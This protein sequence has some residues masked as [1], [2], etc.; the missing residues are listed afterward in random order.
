MPPGRVFNLVD[1]QLPAWRKA[2]APVPDFA[3][4]AART[5]WRGFALRT[6]HNIYGG[7]GWQWDKTANAW[8]CLAILEHYAFIPATNN[9]VFKAT[10]YPIMKKTCEFWEDHLKSC[11]RR[12][13]G[14]AGRLVSGTRPA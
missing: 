7:M 4:P 6:S 14:R 10:A 3:I 9:F 8:Y 2:T 12:E 1:S 5:P 11:C 13:I